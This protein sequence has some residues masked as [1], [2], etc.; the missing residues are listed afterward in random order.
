MSMKSSAYSRVLLPLVLLLLVASAGPGRCLDEIPVPAEAASGAAHLLSLVGPDNRR[1]FQPERLAGLLE[2]IL[3]PKKDGTIHTIA[4]ALDL[5]SAY[6]QVDVRMPLDRVLQYAFNPAI[7]WFATSPS[8]LRSTAWTRTEQPWPALPRLWEQIPKE[9]PP[10]V[11][12]GEEVVENTPDLFSGSYYRYRL[13]RT[14][15]AYVYGGRR[16]VISI[17]R[18][19]DASE[20][21]KKGYTVGKD[22]DWTYFYS[23]EPGLTL[24]GLG[25]VK[26]RMFDSAGISI[27]T[28]PEP[29]VTR[30]GN[31]KWIRAGWNGL[32]VVQND[33]IYHGMTRFAST[34]KQLLESPRLPAVTAFEEA[35]RRIE[36]LNDG[37]LR[38]RMARY[39]K[40]LAARADALEGGARKHL[41]D[42]FWADSYWAGLT[43]EDMRSVLV[44][45]T[46]KALLGKSSDWPD[47][48]PGA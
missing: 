41:P 3:R 5:P 44:L 22:D 36:R 20:V 38:E 34:F 31:L 19:V 26:C 48:L 12:R 2:F 17:S 10:L 7:P 35:C 21:G 27:Y 28:E 32:N 9:G 15:I 47:L 24:G 18:Q 33:H 23:G 30:L 25:W 4:A 6:C 37:E 40:V 29:G 11:V 16:T 1:E 45:E 43:A 8:S 42:P 39:R 46:L 14:L 13:H